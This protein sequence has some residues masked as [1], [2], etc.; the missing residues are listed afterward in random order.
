MDKEKKITKRKLKKYRPRVN[1]SLELAD[2]ICKKLATSNKGIKQLCAE[3]PNWP[4]GETVFLWRIAHKEFG[5][6]YTVAKQHQ[7]EV[8]VDEILQIADDSSKD[9][10]VDENGVEVCNRDWI[11]RSRLKIDTRKWLACKLAPKLYGD[12]V[13]TENTVTVRHED[14]LKE[15]E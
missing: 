4:A 9:T 8:I 10:I 15:L 11:N 5:D 2:E 7:I 6:A 3:N 1:Y 12:K 13:V 14:A